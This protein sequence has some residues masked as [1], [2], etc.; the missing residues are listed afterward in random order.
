MYIYVHVYTPY[1]VCQ[2]ITTL[3]QGNGSDQLLYGYLYV[4][5]NKLR[6]ADAN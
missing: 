6:R 5:A 4:S 2:E 1:N 3:T